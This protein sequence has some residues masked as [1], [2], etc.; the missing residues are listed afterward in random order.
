M[1]VSPGVIACTMISFT[2]RRSPLLT[3]PI[4]SLASTRAPCPIHDSGG[5]AHAPFLVRN[6]THDR[7]PLPHYLRLTLDDLD[8][9]SPHHDRPIALIRRHR[10]G[11]E[12]PT[13]EVLLGNLPK[14]LRALCDHLLSSEATALDIAYRLHFLPRR[15]RELPGPA[16]S[17]GR[18]HGPR[19][20]P[21]A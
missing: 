7:S 3:N 16:G 1:A 19:H 18:T 17:R 12:Y 8:H 6:P 4:N 9:E 20:F 2:A 21:A 10:A 5:L 13:A 15:H 11:E 14:V